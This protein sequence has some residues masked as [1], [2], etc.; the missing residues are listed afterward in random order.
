ME[1]EK[2]QKSTVERLRNVK[3][4]HCLTIS[5]IC[6]M[7]DKKGYFLSE[8]TLKRVFSDNHD[9][10]SFKYRDT[11]APLADVL[12]ELY[13][14]KSGSEDVQALKTMIHDKNKM[15][16]LLVVKN[17][18][19]KK[20]CEKRISHLQ[21]QVEKLEQHLDFRERV[22]QRKDEV[23]EKLLNNVIGE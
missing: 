13:D 19:L 5:E 23:I 22:I 6:T 15:I 8:A 10:L 14:D 11:I 17:E 20:D 3:K 2:L 21:R 4:E 1:I 7:L 18:E 12:L 9:P 16:D